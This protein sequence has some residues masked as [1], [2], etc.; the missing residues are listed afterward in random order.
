MQS[1]YW[2]VWNP[3][4]GRTNVK[5]LTEHAATCEAERLARANP[6]ETFVVLTPVSARRVD[7][8]QRIE[9]EPMPCDPGF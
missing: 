3:G 4:T 5:H 7:N 2:M 9:F 8:M 1:R 6:G